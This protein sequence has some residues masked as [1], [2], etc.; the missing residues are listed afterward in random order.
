MKS[1]LQQHTFYKMMKQ[2]TC[3]K[4][5]EGSSMD[6]LITNSKF[7]F[8]KANSFETCLIDHH[9][10][11][12]TTLKSKFEK[13]KPIKSIYRKQCDSDLLNWTFFIVCLL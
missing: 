12:H 7:S 5:D 6:L 2:N 9:H 8:M 10:M 4:S 11:I 13:F 3:F 1:F